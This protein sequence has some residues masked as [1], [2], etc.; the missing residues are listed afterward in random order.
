MPEVKEILYPRGITGFVF[1][2]KGQPYKE[3]RIG[4]VWR[5]ARAKVGL[6]DLTLYGGTRHSKAS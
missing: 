2:V 4:K 6:N 3:N 5:R 1:N